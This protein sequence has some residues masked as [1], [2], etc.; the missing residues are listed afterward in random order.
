MNALI[1]IT[2]RL[3][4]VWALAWIG[5]TVLML[6]Y[7]PAHIALRLLAPTTAWFALYLPNVSLKVRLAIAWIGVCLTLGAALAADRFSR[8]GGDDAF[9]SFFVLAPGGA[10]LI[11]LAGFLLAPIFKR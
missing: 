3:R 10:V 1:E 2:R 6:V 9:A 7:S 5:I 4:F 11:L 8:Q